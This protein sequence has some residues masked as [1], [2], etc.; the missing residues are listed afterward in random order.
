MGEIKETHNALLHAM[1]T[2]IYTRRYI[3]IDSKLVFVR[4]VGS[5]S[6]LA[7]G[8]FHAAIYTHSGAGVGR[9]GVGLQPRGTG[10]TP[11]M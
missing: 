10:T 6:L 7:L 5:T 2:S 4:A 11:M 8:W 1:D 3:L 9:N